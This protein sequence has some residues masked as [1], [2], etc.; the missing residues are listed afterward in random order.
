MIP[1]DNLDK[2]SFKTKTISW[3]GNNSVNNILLQNENGPCFLISLVNSLILSREL[4]SYDSNGF[5]AL[6]SSNEDDELVPLKSL[7]T[8]K[9]VKLV[10]L[11]NELSLLLLQLNNDDGGNEILDISS[12]LNRLQYLHTG[13]NINPS[14]NDPIVNLAND[15][16]LKICN[17]LG[18]KVI[19]GWLIDQDN[20]ANEDDILKKLDNYENIQNYLL[21]RIDEMSELA[22]KYFFLQKLDMNRF[23][24]DLNYIFEIIDEFEKEQQNNN[25]DNN[26]STIIENLQNY[27]KIK[28]FLLD[29]PTQLTNYGLNKLSEKTLEIDSIS[30]FFRNDHFN[31]I[32][33]HPKINDPSNNDLFLLLID[34]GYN[35]DEMVWECLKTINGDE[36]YLCDGNFKIVGNVNKDKKNNNAVDVDPS[37]SSNNTGGEFIEGKI[38]SDETDKIDYNDY[39][40][41]SDDEKLGGLTNDERIARNLQK[42]ED[43]NYARGLQNR[44]NDEA[45]ANFLKSQKKNKD[46]K[47]KITNTTKNEKNSRPGSATANK[48]QNMGSFTGETTSSINTKATNADTKNKNKS[49]EGC[50]IV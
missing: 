3:N 24:T 39:A 40:L 17:H 1:S 37:N 32:Y 26:I 22:N 20:N 35:N 42:E 23:S 19:H 33:R 30:I 44:F 5:P 46:N 31:T 41:D 6:N 16:V 25:Q 13:I 21:T 34:E 45:T 10:D 12:I 47:K 7:L 48:R 2:I 38:V 36:N 8:A 4:K 18:L 50:V 11:L 27:Y 49:K 14:V 29:N 43:E 15:E 28:S 9:N